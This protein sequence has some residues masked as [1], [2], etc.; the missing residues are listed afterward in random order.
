MY[1]TGDRLNPG[2]KHTLLNHSVKKNLFL[3]SKTLSTF[4]KSKESGVLYF[5]G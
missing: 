2:M 3:I 5:G 1:L 4:M